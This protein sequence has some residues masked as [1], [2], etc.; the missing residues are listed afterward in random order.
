MATNAERPPEPRGTLRMAKMAELRLESGILGISGSAIC[1]PF[2]AAPS[3]VVSRIY[4]FRFG[5]WAS[6]ATPAESPPGPHGTLR[7]GKM[8]EL[9]IECGILWI[10]VAAFCFSS[11]VANLRRFRAFRI[12]ALVVGRQWTP[13]RN[14][15]RGSSGRNA[16]VK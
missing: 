13:P 6:T 10:P 15:S 5:R 14:A 11:P 2:F 8:A 1:F 7:S 9:R 12:S 4:Y 16:A 3:T